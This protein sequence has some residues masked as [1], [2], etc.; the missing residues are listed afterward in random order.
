MTALFKGYALRERH[1]LPPNFI[2]LLQ[3]NIMCH[4]QSRYSFGKGCLLIFVVLEGIGTFNIS[5]SETDQK[6]G[7]ESKDE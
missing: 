4:T 5:V 7:T 2:H 1:P 6:I 3:Y